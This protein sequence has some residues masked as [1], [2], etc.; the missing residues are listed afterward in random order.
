MVSRSALSILFLG[1]WMMI[2]PLAIHH[3]AVASW[4][5][6]IVAVLAIFNGVRLARVEHKAWQATLTF[7]ASACTFLGGF[8]PRMNHGDGLIARSLIFGGLMFVAGI[9]ALGQHREVRHAAPRM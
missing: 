9:S 3:P 4:N 8:I 6:W 1:I 5:S 2:S 7:I